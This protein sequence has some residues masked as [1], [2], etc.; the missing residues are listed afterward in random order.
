MKIHSGKSNSLGKWRLGQIQT[1]CFR[2][3]SLSG[4]VVSALIL[5]I[6]LSLV[7][8]SCKQL[9]PTRP[10]TFCPPPKEP[11]CYQLPTKK[12]PFDTTSTGKFSPETYWKIEVV[13]GANSKLDEWALAFTSNSNAVL[14]ITNGDVQTMSWVYAPSVASLEETSVINSGGVGSVSTPSFL[15]IK[16]VNTAPKVVLVSYYP[17][18][19]KVSDSDIADAVIRDTTVVSVVR[20]SILS[21]D[22]SWDAQPS[23]SADGKYVCF[24]SDRPGGLGGTDIWISRRLSDGKWSEP[25][26][27][28]ESINSTC[29]ELSPFFSP[30]GSELLYSSSGRETVGGYDI[31]SSE[32]RT[33]SQSSAG[34]GISFTKAENLGA[35]LNTP[36]DEL[37]PSTPAKSNSLI[38]Y[39]SNQNK[40]NGFDVFV[41]H[42]VAFPK[43]IITDK[44]P[45]EKQVENKEPKTTSK[46]KDLTQKETKKKRLRGTVYDEQKKPVKNADVSVRDVTDDVV[47]AKTETDTVGRYEVDVPVDREVEITSQHN[48]GFYDTKKMKFND[49][50]SPNIDFVVPTTLYLR[51]NFPN[52]DFQNPYKNSLDSNG[53]ETNQTYEEQLNLLADNLKRTQANIKKVILVGHT[54]ENGASEY[55][56]GLGQRR[57]E[58]VMNELVKRGIPRPLF[59]ARSAGEDE[60]LP[61]RKS[62]PLES[63]YKRNR[64]VELVKIMR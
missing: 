20:N 44:K 26:N 18:G 52:D 17:Y 46:E 53:L 2:L 8:S 54:D 6:T 55:N 49:K 11:Q 5:I 3:F 59:E 62:E 19:A 12:A 51:I 60:P 47:I 10:I 29:D 24:A 50:S 16:N 27:A 45:I 21:K 28:G 4:C 58:F 37:F 63:Y 56:I 30:D 23:V 32:I 7:V 9:R 61:R 15:T 41:R 1:F 48:T 43:R 64:R 42:R 13:D 36:D 39:S 57:V 14:S 40:A 22:G 33:E 35:P 31:F 34:L 38:Y 25:V